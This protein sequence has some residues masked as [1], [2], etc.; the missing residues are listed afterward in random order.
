MLVVLLFR[1][2]CNVLTLFLASVLYSLSPDLTKLRM[3]TRLIDPL[4]SNSFFLFG[5]RGTGKTT[6]LRNLFKDFRCLWIDLLNPE[7]EKFIIRPQ[8]LREVVTAADYDWVIIDEVQRAPKLLDVVHALIENPDNLDRHLK[9][10]LTGSSARSLKRGAANLLA[11]RLFTNNLYPLLAREL[12]SDFDL[13]THLAWG[14]LPLIAKLSDREK[15]AYLLSYAST[16]LKEEIFGEQVVRKVMPFRKFLPIAAQVSGSIVNYSSIAKD[17]GVD[18]ATVRSYFQILVDTLIGF[19]L[20]AYSR[21][22]RKQQLSFPKFY[23]FDTGVMRALSET[24]SLP[25]DSGQVRGPLFEQFVICEAMRLGDYLQTDFSFSY[26]ATKGGLEID[27]VIERPGKKTLM[28][29]IKASELVTEN[30]VRH[31]RTLQNEF[32]DI[33][34]MCLSRDVHPRVVNGVRV[35]PWEQGL[36]EIFAGFPGS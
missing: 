12:G 4:L 34:V 30:H 3:Y 21:S 35:M 10:A 14:G 15:R 33:E 23:L 18:W 5:A 27:L 8:L 24:L 28:I 9:F 25:I 22:L 31:L 32:A 19:E 20:P 13:D 16:Y 17:L 7:E 2:P 36:E 6:L 1:Y 26:L 29:E 11:G